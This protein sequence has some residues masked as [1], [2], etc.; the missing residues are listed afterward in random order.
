MATGRVTVVLAVMWVALAA[1]AAADGGNRAPAPSPTGAATGGLPSLQT[2]LLS[3]VTAAV[4]FS[5]L[6]E[7]I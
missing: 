2:V 6:K 7:L 1:L 3:F 4:S 5:T